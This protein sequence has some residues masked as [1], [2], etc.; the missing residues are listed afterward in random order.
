MISIDY[1]SVNVCELC[2]E[3]EFCIRLHN[4]GQNFYWYNHSKY[5]ETFTLKEYGSC[6]G[7]INL[8]SERK[9]YS[10]HFDSILMTQLKN[11]HTLLLKL[12][13]RKWNISRYYNNDE[14]L[15]RT[16]ADFC[17]FFHLKRFWPNQ[18]K[19]ELGALTHLEFIWSVPKVHKVM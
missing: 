10:K 17:E 6:P 3:L 9:P 4:E 2:H 1:N 18:D 15:A 19:P 5:F 13:K 7:H 11:A 12:L 8:K 16:R 14:C